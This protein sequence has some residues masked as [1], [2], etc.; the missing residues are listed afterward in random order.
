[1]SGMLRSGERCPAH[2]NW[3]LEQW[4]HSVG[5]GGGNWIPLLSPRQI[6]HGRVSSQEEAGADSC[7]EKHTPAA[8]WKLDCSR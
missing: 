4:L 3:N 5:C 6:N 2:L 8:A 1:M 7:F